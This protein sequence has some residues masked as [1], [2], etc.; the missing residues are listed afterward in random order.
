MSSNHTFVIVGA[1]YAGAKAAEKLRSEGFDGR[2]VLVG[3]EPDRPYA[4]P[5]LSKGYLRGEGDRP[6]LRDEAFYEENAIELRTSTRATELDV[7]G[8]ALSLS[9]GERLRFDRL[10]LV[11]GAEPRRLPVPGADLDGV[12]RL[13]EVRDSDAIRDR[14]QGGG[15]LVVVGAGWIGSEVAASA[16]ELG[17]DVTVVERGQVP[18]EHVLGPTVG[19]IYAGIHSDHGVRLVA[20]A[21]IEA[22]EGESSVEGVRLADGRTIAAATVVVG[23]GVAPRTDLAAAAGLP[24]ENGIV[25]DEY[26]RTEVPSIFAAGDVANA[27]HPMYGRHLRVEHLMTARHQSEAAALSMLGTGEPYARVP[28]FFSDQ[29]D[30]AMEY[31]GHATSWDEVVLR[32][33]VAGREFI[34]FWV[35]SGRVVAGMNVNVPGVSDEIQELVR[36]GSEVDTMG[37]RDPSVPL[38]AVA[39]PARSAGR[40][41][42]LGL[43][44]QGVGY[45]RRLVSGRLAK[46]DPTP[47]AELGPGEAR[48]LQVDGEKV[49]A[50]R[51]PQG[52]LHAVSAVCTHMGCVVEWNG[53]DT[54]WDCP[55]HGGRFDIDGRVL[56]G[57]P[58][59]PLELKVVEGGTAPPKAA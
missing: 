56:H 3:E 51:D 41:R 28:Y 53:E 13:R 22:L 19:E 44:R 59:R 34:A 36:S 47:A 37:L 30:V 33:D 39:K 6:Y 16:R 35:E 58:K 55:C 24:V 46:G 11:T 42:S 17:S 20:G 21:Q 1:G 32:G 25:V 40:G 18:L 48:V 14:L 26:L 31:S 9:D 45:P 8:S 50:Y 43:V 38:D 4:R 27:H 5:P 23:V 57:P 54:A 29:Y 2:V 7:N 15:P 10:L 52:E 49:A 12:L